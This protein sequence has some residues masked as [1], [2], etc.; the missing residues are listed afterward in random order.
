MRLPDVNVLVNAVAEDSPHHLTA[1]RWLEESLARPQGVGMAWLVL[2]GFLRISTRAGIAEPPLAVDQAV[3]V[4][5][6]WLLHPHACIVHPGER[7]AGLL[8]RLLVA[9][10]SAGNLTNDAH[11]AA[12]AIEHSAEVLTFDRGFARFAGLRY[13]LLS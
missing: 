2:V 12:L 10:G 11:L 13:K 9:A 5:D 8:G 4:V 3:S 7:H 1:R 6:E